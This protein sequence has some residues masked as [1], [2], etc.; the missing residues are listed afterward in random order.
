VVGELDRARTSWMS[1]LELM[2]HQLNNGDGARR[3]G[4][5]NAF[6]S[7]ALDCV[8]PQDYDFTGFKSETVTCAEQAVLAAQ[9]GYTI[10]RLQTPWSDQQRTLLVR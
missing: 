3:V 2:E 5:G 7:I 9:Q 10:R 8:A 4:N 6:P 1:T